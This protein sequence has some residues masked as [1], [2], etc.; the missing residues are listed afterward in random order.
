[1]HKL[2][3]SIY[4]EHSTPE[5][6]FAYMELAAKYGFKRIFTCLL[7]VDQPKEYIIKEF[8]AFTDKAHALGFEVSVDTDTNVFKHLG[9]TPR[10][11]SVFKEI[12]AD[13]IRLDGHFDDYLDRLI[14]H[15]PEGIKIEF[16]GSSDTSVDHLLRHG[17][18]I[19]NMTVCHNFY[20]ERYSG[21]GWKT[22][23]KFNEKWKGLGLHT[24]A[25]VSSNAQNTYGPW[26][27]FE[28]LPT[29]EIDR[30]L[31]IDV[32]VR[33]LLACEM[34]D[35]ILIGNAIADEAELKAMAEVDLTKTTIGVHPVENLHKEEEHILF[36]LTHAGRTDHSDY[37]IRSSL[38]RSEYRNKSIPVKNVPQKTFTR[39]DVVIVNDDLA[40]YRGEC[41]V[42][43]QEIENDGTRNLVGRIPDNE[44]MIL[45][46]MEEHPDHLFGFVRK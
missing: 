9:A 21:L 15:N 44:M 30:G 14:T 10:D 17:A 20:P 12:G 5:K 27:V 28:G 29:V 43:L 22:F 19:H 11:V 24:A 36:D 39:G 8:K 46:L 42:V 35:D 31:P 23:M 13:I 2:G 6:D 41:E 25:F 1:M 33:H 40:H 16:N 18:D 26:P 32:Q 38:T 37:Y 45:D 7:S 4:P 34:I 3:I